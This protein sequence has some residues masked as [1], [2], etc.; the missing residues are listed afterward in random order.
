MPADIALSKKM[1]GIDM[2]IEEDFLGK[3]KVPVDAYYG[4]FTARAK[5]NFRL[6]GLNVDVE[7]IRS[8]ALI[9]KCAGCRQPGARCPRGK[10]GL[11]HN[12]GRPGNHRRE[13]RR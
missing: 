5:E 4:S 9:K 1:R 8:L 12:Q 3:V 11:G 10:A 6:S 7:L 13:A 2:R